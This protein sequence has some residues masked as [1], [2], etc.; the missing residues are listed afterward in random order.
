MGNIQF[1]KN[2]TPENRRIGEYLLGVYWRAAIISKTPFYPITNWQGL[3]SFYD[4][5]YPTFVEYLGDWS[6]TV[7]VEKLVAVMKKVASKNETNYPRPSSFNNSI[8]DVVGT[9]DT[10]Q[11]LAQTAT[12]VGSALSS[13]T[14]GTFKTM[15]V[16]ATCAFA[17][18]V[19]L[20]S[21]GKIK[22]PKN[23]KSMVP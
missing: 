20:K 21:G 3:L 4:T 19:Y 14:I 6:K 16:I 5:K 9:V 23:L 15:I 10:T 12:D 11:V 7:T 18:A 8:S 1:T 13:F 2:V 17:L 22:I